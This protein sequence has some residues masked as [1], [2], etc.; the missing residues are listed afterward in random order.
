MGY[1]P[2]AFD[3]SVCTRHFTDEDLYGEVRCDYP[4]CERVMCMNC[5]ALVHNEGSRPLAWCPDHA[6]DAEHHLD[7]SDLLPGHPVWDKEK[8]LGIMQNPIEHYTVVRF[9]EGSEW[10]YTDAEA[11]RFLRV[12]RGWQWIRQGPLG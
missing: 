12:L 8:G 11:A 2:D 4:L 5:A 6:G 1:R 7:V 9:G 10:E 3:C